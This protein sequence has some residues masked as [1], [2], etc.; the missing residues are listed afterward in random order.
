MPDA[1]VHGVGST[2]PL[3]SWR[4]AEPVSRPPVTRGARS[5]ATSK[6]V[7]APAPS[8]PTRATISPRATCR[9]TFRNAGESV[10]G[11]QK[12][13]PSRVSDLT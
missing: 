10:A 8:A 6:S 5:A 11:Y 13:T 4:A 9:D 3:R 2:I 1:C 7:E 12:L